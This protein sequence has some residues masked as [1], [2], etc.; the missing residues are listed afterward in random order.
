MKAEQVESH[1]THG[2]GMKQGYWLIYIE[3]LRF[4]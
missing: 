2:K 3:T 1:K 4:N